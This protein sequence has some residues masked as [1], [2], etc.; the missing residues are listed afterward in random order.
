[1][2]RNKKGAWKTSSIVMAAIGISL[3][4]I[5]VV[6]SAGMM[7]VFFRYVLP[8][9]R[10]SAAITAQTTTEDKNTGDK[11]TAG[12][13]DSKDT[14]SSTAAQE[15]TA[16]ANGTDKTEAAS[17]DK[18]FSVTDAATLPDSGSKTALSVTEIANSVGPATVSVNVEIAYSAYGQTGTAQASGSGFIVSSDG[19]IVTNNHVIE[20]AT[21]I[22]VIIPGDTEP[23]DAKVVGTDTRT[24][25]AV[26]KID[27]TD[28]PYVTLG[29]SSA[30]QA[31]E[32]A[33]AIGNPFGDLAGTVTAGVISALDREVTISGQTYNLLQ[34]DASINSGNSGGPLVNSYGEVIGVTNAK[35]SEGEGLGF[36]IPINDIKSVIEDLV[37]NGYVTGRPT[38]GIGVISVDQTNADQYGWPVGAYVKEITKGGAAEKAGVKTGDII[39][40]VDGTAVTSSED[41]SAIKNSHKVGDSIELTIYRNGDTIK[42]SIVLE[43]AK[44]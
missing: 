20:G 37:N 32:L 4:V 39:T 27:R 1:M 40:A 13:T 25:I 19:Y 44:A 10:S 22:K 35:V 28:L 12:T 16:A 34:T 11:E 38:I 9:N 7:F 41:V 3:A 5:L 26:L 17:T 30:L 18:H 31:G 15:T 36:A 42:V 14:S 23:V 33:V 29:D 8:E 21:N 24:D 2:K 6:G 43:E